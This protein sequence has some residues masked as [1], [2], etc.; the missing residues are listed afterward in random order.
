MYVCK[1]NGEIIRGISL[2]ID[3]KECPNNIVISDDSERYVAKKFFDEK[4]SIWDNYKQHFKYI[5]GFEKKKDVLNKIDEMRAREL[6][7]KL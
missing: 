7:K 5:N 2:T 1:Y 4:W 3:C 6:A